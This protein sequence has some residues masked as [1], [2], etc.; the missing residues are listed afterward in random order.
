MTCQFLYFQTEVFKCFLKGSTLEEIYSNVALE[1]NYWLSILYDQG[2][3]LSLS[4]LFELIG[5]SKNMSRALEDYGSQKSTS[6]TT[7]K[8]LAECML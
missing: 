5:E 3:A 7:A 6:I 1:A 4:E 2:R 8:R